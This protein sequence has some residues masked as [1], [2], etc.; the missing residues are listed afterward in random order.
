ME[1]ELARGEGR[2]RIKLLSNSMGDDLV[3]YIY[4]DKAHVGAVAMAEH[5]SQSGRVS[6]SVI[7]RPGHKDDAIAAKAAH[8]IGKAVRGPVCVIA[9]VHIDNITQEEI[10][11]V[12]ANAEAVVEDFICSFVR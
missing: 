6:T 4:N 12:T 2:T 9:G 3:V 8:A 7:T 11:T 1:P 10:D 5:D